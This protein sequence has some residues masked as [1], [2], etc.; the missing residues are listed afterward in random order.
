MTVPKTLF[1]LTCKRCGE[2]VAIESANRTR[3]TCL[4]CVDIEI[5]NNAER[6]RARLCK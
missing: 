1:S 6:R 3:R 4:A 2:R 5:K